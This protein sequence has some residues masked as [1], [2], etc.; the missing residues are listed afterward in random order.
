MQGTTQK[1]NEKY[2]QDMMANMLKQADDMLTTVTNMEKMSSI[3]VQMAAVTNSMVT[4]MKDMTLDIAE[5]R[6]NISNFDD[7]FRP[8]RNYFYWEPHCFNI[9]GC[10]ALRSIFDTL[11]GIDVMTDDIEAIIPDMER[12]NAL[13]PQMVAL[14][15]SMIATMKNM[16]TYM[17][18]MYQTQKGIH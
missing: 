10:W 16:R 15:P 1:M 14:M 17:L 12:L 9:P 7:F 13:M 5:L 2:Q 8:M 4:K 11:D 6:D 3:T 18:T